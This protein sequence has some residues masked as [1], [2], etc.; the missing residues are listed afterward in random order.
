[1]KWMEQRQTENKSLSVQSSFRLTLSLRSTFN[2]TSCCI[3]IMFHHRIMISHARW[4]FSKNGAD[5][6]IVYSF[7]RC[8]CSA[9]DDVTRKC[10][11]SASDWSRFTT[12]TKGDKGSV[13]RKDELSCERCLG[14][15]TNVGEPWVKHQNEFIHQPSCCR[16]Y[17]TTCSFLSSPPHPPHLASFRCKQHF[18]AWLFTTSKSTSHHRRK[19]RI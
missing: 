12:I 4:S 5:H 15:L 16:R 17:T 18:F 10:F 2:A 1:M 13:D 14:W 3:Q 9:F 19:M 7:T 11:D 6:A 8:R